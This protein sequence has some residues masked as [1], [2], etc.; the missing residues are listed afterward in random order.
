MKLQSAQVKSHHIII[1]PQY[2]SKVWN[3]CVQERTLC[4]SARVLR[5]NIRLQQSY[6]Q[7]NLDG[8]ATSLCEL[9]FVAAK[10]GR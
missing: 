4:I 5:T 1:A 8:L 9:N 6:L 3:F 7:T 10:H 2:S